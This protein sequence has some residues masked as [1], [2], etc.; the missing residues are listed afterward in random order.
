[1]TAT[2][3]EIL[4]EALARIGRDDGLHLLGPE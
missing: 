2:S 1:M 3:S 4:A